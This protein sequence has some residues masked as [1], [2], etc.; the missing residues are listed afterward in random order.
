[1]FLEKEFSIFSDFYF[2]EPCLFPSNLDSVETMNT[3]I[4]ERPNHSEN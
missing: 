2:R 4:Q 3:L 1:M